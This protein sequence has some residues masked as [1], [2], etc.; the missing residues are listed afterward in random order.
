M[1]THHNIKMFRTREQ[2]FEDHVSFASGRIIGEVGAR[3]AIPHDIYHLSL[4]MWTRMGAP[5]TIMVS[6]RAVEE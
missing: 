5:D 4:E 2:P 3:M 1:V 6:V